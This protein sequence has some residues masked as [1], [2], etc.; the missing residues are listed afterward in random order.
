MAIY[1][2]AR[3]TLEKARLA[4]VCLLYYYINTTSVRKVKSVPAQERNGK[5]DRGLAAHIDTGGAAVNGL[6]RSRKGESPDEPSA[7][8]GF[9]SLGVS[10]S[11]KDRS[12]PRP[13][14]S[15]GDENC[16]CS[17]RSSDRAYECNL[18]GR[19]NTSMD[20]SLLISSSSSGEVRLR[21][22]GRTGPQSTPSI[23][24][25]DLDAARKPND[26]RTLTISVA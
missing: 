17:A 7:S 2:S 11:R 9:E 8:A 26:A 6:A 21:M 18:S 10:K 12:E 23:A 1:E 3:A 25:T 15:S 5:L 24:M 20:N 22:G 4:N 16:S 19:A 13:I 14:T